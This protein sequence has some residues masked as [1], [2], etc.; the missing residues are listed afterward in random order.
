M[1]MMSPAKLFAELIEAVVVNQP[2]ADRA[3]VLE[4][5]GQLAKLVGEK[6]VPEGRV[7]GRS[8]VAEEG[9]E[10]PTRGL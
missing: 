8:M 3:E 10:P 9:L 4:I 2:D 6:V 5:R 1:T 7:R